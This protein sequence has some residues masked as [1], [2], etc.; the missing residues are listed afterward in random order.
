M[1]FSPTSAPDP[2]N[3]DLLENIRS[4]LI[5]RGLVRDPRDGTNQS[6]LAPLW[7]DPRHGVPAPAQTEGLK[8]VEASQVGLVLGIFP[9][10]DIPSARYESFLR[11]NHVRFV[12]RGRT[13]QP[14]LSMS[15]SV[16]AALNDKRGWMMDHV[17]VNESLRFRGLQPIQRDNLGFTYEEEYSFL[18]WAPFAVVN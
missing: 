4:Y 7:I 9:A 18:L 16:W 3:P 15:N 1:S 11:K 6:T 14:V 5:S 2:T 17:E 13:S 12:Y 8:P 10:T